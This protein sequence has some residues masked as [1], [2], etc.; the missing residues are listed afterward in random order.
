MSKIKKQNILPIPTQFDKSKL[1]T[2]GSLPNSETVN[3]TVA[4]LTGKTLIEPTQED[5]SPTRPVGRPK[6]MPAA[7]RVPYNTMVHE[8]N[9][10]RL[11]ILAAKKR[12]SAADLLE[13]A[14]LDFFE[15]YKDM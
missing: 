1:K 8:D 9:I 15:K 12:V 6:K 10:M 5:S 4:S 2:T 3:Q 13:E 7:G 14:L 11:K